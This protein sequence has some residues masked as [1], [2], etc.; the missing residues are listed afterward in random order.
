ML[1]EIKLNMNEIPYLPPR[2]V[3][4]A[5]QKALSKI[6]RYPRAKDLEV[7]R[8]L[9][10]DYSGVQKRHIILSPGSELLLR[11]IIHMFSRGR[12]VI[13]VNPSFFPTVQ[14]ANQFATKSVR[15]QLRP[16]E[17]NL[18][19]ELIVNELSEP[20]LVII[21][22]PN[23]PTSKILMDKRM[24]KAIIEDKNTLLVIDEAYYE[25]SGVTFADMVEE[26]PNLAVVRTM[27]KAFGLAGARIGYL[28]AGDDFL[29]AFSTFYAFLPQSSLY[30]AM[31][32]VRDP[33]YIKR[34]IEHT[35][36]E[37][38]RMSEKLEEMGLQVYPSNTNFLLIKTDILDLVR[39]LKARGVLVLDLSSQW[40]SGFVRVSVGTPKENDIFLSRVKEIIKVSNQRNNNKL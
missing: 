23:N 2:K 17:F 3:T 4:D 1:N 12:K 13:M 32:A 11:E 18:S 31:E 26:H 8:K 14:C 19:S 34:N 39:E 28:I 29:D 22:N 38:E 9:L 21:D 33:S 35:I 40:L 7:L 25:F 20:C 30:V 27:D 16:P 6:N 36:A 5:A 24:A 37:R 10:A 15:V